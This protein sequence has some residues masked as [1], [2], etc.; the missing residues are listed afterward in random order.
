MWYIDIYI[1]FSGQTAITEKMHH[2]LKIYLILDCN[3]SL[4][5]NVNIVERWVEFDT[6]AAPGGVYPNTAS[7]G[8]IRH[9]QIISD[10]R[11]TRGVWTLQIS[12]IYLWPSDSGEL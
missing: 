10:S 11:T 6:G 9:L 2:Y 4:Y 12:D 8:H 3:K 5:L 1:T 7:H